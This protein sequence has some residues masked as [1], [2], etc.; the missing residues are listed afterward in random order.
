MQIIPTREALGAYLDGEAAKAVGNLANLKA[1]AE[2]ALAE[3]GA[4][5]AKR[6]GEHDAIAAT[7]DELT[8]RALTDDAGINAL[9]QA[10]GALAALVAV[11]ETAKPGL[12]GAEA[13]RLRAATALATAGKA[14]RD[15]ALAAYIA[16]VRDDVDGPAAT[17]LACWDRWKRT[18]QHDF[19]LAD[20]REA[21]EGFSPLLDGS[22]TAWR[23][24]EM[25]PVFKRAF[26]ACISRLRI[27]WRP[28]N[29]PFDALPPGHYEFLPQDIAAMQATITTLLAAQA[30]TATAA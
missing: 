23:A 8:R 14:A 11:I 15:N 3:I 17:Y 21:R 25:V 16:A 2:S 6:Q 12:Q 13:D 5:V 1:T 22:L 29:G 7:L 28:A 24:P 10:R 9:S 30:A 20:W 19:D 26:I 27:D 4:Q 18:S